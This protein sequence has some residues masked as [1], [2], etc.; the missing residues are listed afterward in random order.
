M[1]DWM[2]DDVLV[3]KALCRKYE[4]LWR[5]TRLTVHFDMYSESCMAVKKQLVRVNLL[6]CKRKSQTAMVIRRSFSNLLTPCYDG[7]KKLRY[8]NMIHHGLRYEHFFN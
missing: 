6:Y 8:L 2:S 5:K 3:L 7:I 1:N 4:S